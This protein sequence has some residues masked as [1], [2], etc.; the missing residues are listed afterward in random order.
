M[1]SLSCILKLV[2]AQ[3]WEQYETNYR[4]KI[5]KN[6]WNFKT[7][8]SIP[9]LSCA[10]V[11]VTSPIFAV[12]LPGAQLILAVL[13]TWILPLIQRT[14]TG[15]FYGVSPNFRGRIQTRN[16]PREELEFGTHVIWSK[17]AHF[18]VI[19]SAWTKEIP[20]VILWNFSKKIWLQLVK[21]ADPEK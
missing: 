5:K 3:N 1:T 6:Y 21:L 13:F 19:S 11:F 17:N 12:N 10:L 16:S 14:C 4:Q 7:L 9:F 8:L 2:S 20:P 18:R 15:T